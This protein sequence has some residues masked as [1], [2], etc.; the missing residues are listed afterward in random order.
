MTASSPWTVARQPRWIGALVAT[1]AIAAG[2]VLLSQWQIERS[3]EHATVIERD[4]ETVVSLDSVA[5][6]Q[7]G[8]TSASS[9]QRVELDAALVPGDTTVIQGRI[10]HGVTGYWVTGHVVTAEGVSLAIAAGWTGSE[11]DA[12]KAAGILL[13]SSAETAHI[14]G[15]YLPSEGSY[16][17][18]FENDVRSS[19]AVATLINE[20]A[21]PPEAVYGGY[22][23]V[24]A[25]ITGLETI[26]SPKPSADVTLNWLNIFYAIE[27]IVFAG[28]ALYLWWRL[29]RDAWERE[30]LEREDE[31]EAQLEA[32]AQARAAALAEV[33]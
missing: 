1:L 26:D 3:I 31:L 9:G 18:D 27:W 2:F 10:N 20:W 28:F 11:A 30:E 32:K 33:N 4:T 16:D 7:G 22:V 5:T 24:D 6:P 8:V 25:P 21:E 12:Q 17:D 15:R 29:V 19:M 13:S 23:I 14:I